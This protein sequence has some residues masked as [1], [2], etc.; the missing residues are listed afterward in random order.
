M[1][2][3]LISHNTIANTW[4]TQYWADKHRGLPKTHYT[5]KIH[6]VSYY[7]T[8]EPLDQ[9]YYTFGFRFRMP[10]FRNLFQIEPLPMSPSN[11]LI[12][13]QAYLYNEGEHSE[14]MS[15]ID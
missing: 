6:S 9:S 13:I 7:G 11:G 8:E 3:A 2:P 10:F 5:G 14:S 12:Y 4:R 15:D 1:K